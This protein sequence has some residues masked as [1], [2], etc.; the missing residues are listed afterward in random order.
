MTGAILN[1]VERLIDNGDAETIVR[2]CTLGA[3]LELAKAVHAAD[4]S[5]RRDFGTPT[6]I[7]AYLRGLA[8]PQERAARRVLAEPDRPPAVPL[9]VAG[10]VHG[11]VAVQRQRPS[12]SPPWPVAIG[13][14]TTT[15]A[16][17]ASAREPQGP[18]HA[19]R[20]ATPKEIGTASARLSMLQA[21]E[22]LGMP[23][24][25]LPATR[26]VFEALRDAGLHPSI[27]N[28][29]DIDLN[30]ADVDRVARDREAQ[31]WLLLRLT[32]TVRAFGYIDSGREV[33]FDT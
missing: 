21:G 3:S 16:P 7:A 12:G 33:H 31:E 2:C 24:H 9:N 13:A 14:T 6:A 20:L 27:L 29:I 19:V 17:R 18:A 23:M 1:E 10:V 8:Q 11:G 15:Q 22:R 26:G 25:R 4:D 28:G 5:A 30:A 32:K